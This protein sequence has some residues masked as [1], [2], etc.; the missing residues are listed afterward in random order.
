MTQN[1]FG[2]RLTVA[3]VLK[4]VDLV[5]KTI[6]VMGCNNGIGFETM[7]ALA[8][9]G[10]HVIGL[11]RTLAAAQASCARIPGRT[12]PAACDLADL[13]TITSAVATVKGS[14]PQA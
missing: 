12:T 6:L 1:T 14:R 4:G 5:G 2:A 9:R 11:A 13:A 3:E 10:A 8:G 7:R